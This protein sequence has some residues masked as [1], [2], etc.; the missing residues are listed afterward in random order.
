MARA[1]YRYFVI[2]GMMRTG[3]NLLQRTLDQLPSLNCHGELFNPAFINGPTSKVNF[4]M[5]T[6]ERDANPTSL[7]EAMIAAGD[8]NALSGFRLFDGHNLQVTSAVLEDPSAAKIVL[9]RNPLDSFVSLKIARETDQWMLMKQRA[10]RSVQ[11]HFDITEYREYLA[12]SESYYS[13][14]MHSLKVSGQTAFTVDYSEIPDLSIINGLS[15]WL[16]QSD[17]LDTVEPTI[18]R[19]NPGPLE[20]KVANYAEMIEQLQG[21]GGLHRTGEGARSDRAGG[22]RFMS[23]AQRA[24]LLYAAIPGGPNEQVHRWMHGI[25]GGDSQRSDFA[26]MMADTPPFCAPKNRKA[27]TDWLQTHPG[28]VCFTSVRH[29]VARAYDVFMAKFFGSNDEDIFPRIRAHAQKHYG[30]YLPETGSTDR[31]ALELAGYGVERHRE[32]FSAFLDFLRANLAGRTPMRVDALWA[33]QHEFVEGFASAVTLSLILREE[34][35]ISGAAY[36]KKRF[37]LG[38]VRNAVLRDSGPENLFSLRE[39]WTPQIESQC[40]AAYG[41]DYLQFGFSDWQAN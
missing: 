36:L 8:H 7:I 11:I 33:P 26:D 18:L 5:S 2:L 31:S 1:P 32:S 39:I 10:R 13:R 25:D 17:R 38:D 22:L 37:G 40:R 3:S 14:V 4:G 23:M 19:Q 24:P 20:E 41:R 34:D 12:Q 9:R 6:A 16:G 27:L 15:T 30:M 28:N 29:P 35:L 21:E